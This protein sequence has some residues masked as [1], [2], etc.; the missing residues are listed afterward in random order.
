MNRNP[1]NWVPFSICKYILNAALS[2]SFKIFLQILTMQKN[3][4]FL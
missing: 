3:V 2:A 1:G 4:Y